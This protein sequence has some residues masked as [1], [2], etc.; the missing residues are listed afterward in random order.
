MERHPATADSRVEGPCAISPADLPEMIALVNSVMRQG[1]GQDIL[2][3]YPLVYRDVEPAKRFHP[4]SEWPDRIRRAVHPRPIVMEGCA[5]TVGII[6]SHRHHPEHRRRGYAERCLQRAIRRMRELEIEISA[7]WT[8]VA[9]FPLYE[10]SGYHAARCQSWVYPA[11]RGDAG[12]FPDHGEEVRE[13]DPA[14]RSDLDAIRALR[15]SEPSGVQRR[16]D[17]FAILLDLP[18]MTTWLALRGGIPA[19]Y[20]VASRAV[21]KPGLI[22]GA[23]DARAL[24]TLIRHSLCAI[25]RR[26][27]RHGAC[28]FD[29]ERPARRW[30]A[31]CR[32]AGSP[33][34]ARI[35]CSAST[36][37]RRSSER[38]S[39]G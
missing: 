4:E 2:T 33:G 21:N 35:S 38:S 37:S 28:P 16:A 39:P 25:A 1:T 19:A 9:T 15:A 18:R 36:T 34:R 29:I 26:R 5:F 10:R 24:E 32:T 27:V 17:E 11:G 30:T 12:L 23:G 7:L 6:C 8:Q 22:E 3:D 13:Y 20:L 14:S 31:D